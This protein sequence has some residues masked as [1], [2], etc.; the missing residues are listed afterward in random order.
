M[1]DMVSLV[2]GDTLANLKISLVRED[3]GTAFGVDSNSS[4]RLYIRKKGTE[5]LLDTVD[6][7]DTLST[8]SQGLFV[9]KLGDAGKFLTLS[10]VSAG[11][12]EGEVE[13]TFSADN[14]VQTVFETV[15][16]RVR[17]DFS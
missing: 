2:K 9:F 4:V 1:A 11:Y 7:D 13:I 6:K 3:N 14:T 12:Y 17:D 5:T 8:E 10:T 15:T 16:F